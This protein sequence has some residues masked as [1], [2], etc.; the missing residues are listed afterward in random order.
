MYTDIDF[1]GGFLSFY[2]LSFLTKAR[3]VILEGEIK[4]Y[5]F[6]PIFFSLSNFG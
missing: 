6:G 3:G 5:I 2:D 4:V 1:F